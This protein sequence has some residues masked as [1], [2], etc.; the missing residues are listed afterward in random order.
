LT[1]WRGLVTVAAMN[2]WCIRLGLVLLC[3]LVMPFRCPAPLIYRAGE[4]W[5]Y[6][7]V[8]GGKWERAR[9]KDQLEVAQTAFDKKQYGVALKASRRVVKRW[10]FS[11]YAPKAQYLLG[12]CYETRH[13]DQK[14]FAEYQKLLEKYP[15]VDNYQDVLQ[16]QFVIANRFLG[17]QWFKL[18]GYIPFFPSMDKTCDMYEKVVKNGPFSEVGPP[19]QMNIGAAREKQKD[20]PK[21]VKAYE[22]AADRY[23]DQKKVAADAVYRGGMAYNKEAKSSEY[24]QSV[25]GKAIASLTDFI[26]LYPDDPRVAEA[27]KTINTLKTEQAR[28]SYETAK[29]YEKYKRWNGALIYYNEVLL[30][31]PDSRY[32]EEAKHRIDALKSRATRK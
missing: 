17:G 28:G 9:A 24:D 6:E 20:Y 8:G 14:A 23:H 11:D 19:A 22:K 25:A 31:D 30:K 5:T 29:F 7:S 21:A 1:W 3:V 26:A 12:R 2:R 15:K 16:R 10:P 4:G 27:Q 32:A 18:W 13:M